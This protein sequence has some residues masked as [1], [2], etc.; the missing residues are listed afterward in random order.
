MDKDY[1]FALSLICDTPLAVRP[2]FL[3]NVI[4][5]LKGK[6]E[7]A[8][9]VQ[10]KNEHEEARA[11]MLERFKPQAS[12]GADPYAN[13]RYACVIDPGI[14]IVSLTG[15]LYPR[16]NL[17]TQYCG[18]VSA[19]KLIGELSALIEDDNIKSIVI[20]VDSPGGVV[21]K[22][23][24]VSQ[25]IRNARGKKRITA[26]VSGNGA[27]A[28][29]W[30]L[31]A[32]EKVVMSSTAAVGCLGTMICYLDDS[33]AMEEAGM[34][35]IIII[36]NQTPNKNLPPTTPEGKAQLQSLVDDMTD[37]M[38]QEIATNRGTSV[39]KVAKNFGSG[40]M[41]LAADAVSRGMA[42]EI[43]TME[44]LLTSEGAANTDPEVDP[45][46][47]LVIPGIDDDDT[48]GSDD[49]DTDDSDPEDD[50]DI[51]ANHTE[52]GAMSAMTPE[53]IKAAHPDAYKAIYKAAKAEGI[54][55]EAARISAIDAIK[56]PGYEETIAKHRM[57]PGMTAEKLSGIIL[58]AQNAKRE[59]RAAA[60]ETDAEKVT[61][62]AH[63]PGSPAAEGAEAEQA[64]VIAQGTQ[65][66]NS[67]PRRNSPAK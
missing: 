63:L 37:T 23:D 9:A 49:D 40:A 25:L 52:G 1:A 12:A 24:E 13:F 8:K 58:E 67:N 6:G 42:D 47:N 39:Q 31:S 38:F 53:Q 64:A 59:N 14:A 18:A 65:V 56:A 32:C 7:P 36:S 30:I 28:A 16:A 20:D 21:T 4:S 50:E 62:Q 60:L 55:A 57:E 5:I 35:E 54:A 45:N 44:A 41:V 17:F 51:E 26:Y 29:Y 19:E 66:F 10:I 34:Q 43:M 2:E 33:K 3:T 27:S 15:P 22:T 11:R 48:E 61:E 46:A